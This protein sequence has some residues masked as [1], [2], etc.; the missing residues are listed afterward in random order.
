MKTSGFFGY[1]NEAEKTAA[2]RGYEVLEFYENE[3]DVDHI[4]SKLHGCKVHAFKACKVL[5]QDGFNISG[6][7]L[8]VRTDELYKLRD[9][10][11]PPEKPKKPVTRNGRRKDMARKIYKMRKE[12]DGATLH[13]DDG[14]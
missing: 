12:D 8:Y 14:G 2:E 1:N 4:L 13:S 9:D 6:W 10:Y 11:V 7:A 3:D 5:K